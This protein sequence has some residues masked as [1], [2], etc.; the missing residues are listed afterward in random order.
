MS[1]HLDIRKLLLGM[2]EYDA[3]D[4]HVKPGSPPVVHVS[5]TLEGDR[6]EIAVEDEGI[7]FD[8][9]PVVVLTTSRAD[10]DVRASYQLAAAGS[11]PSR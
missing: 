2:R 6:C 9:I 5:S 3:S 7:G 10:Q 8:T 11:S 4:L 1:D